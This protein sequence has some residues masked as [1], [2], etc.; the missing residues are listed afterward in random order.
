M[1]QRVLVT[2]GG[3]FIGSHL[4]E[5]LEATGFDVSV[6]DNFAVNSKVKLPARVKIFRADVSN[7]KVSD[8]VVKLKPR[9]V[10][11]LAAD[12]RVTSPPEA[13]IAS[14]IIGTYNLL[15]G[16]KKAQAKQF[17]FTSSAAVYGDSKRLPIK[18]TDPTRPISAYGISKLTGEVYCGLFQKHFLTSI[19]RFANVYGPRQSSAAEGGA[20][21]IFIRKMLTGE[22]LIVYGD[23]R[24]TRDFVFVGDV[25]DALMLALEKHTSF[26]V[27]IGSGKEASI[28]EL[29]FQ[30]ESLTKIKPKINNQPARPVEIDHSLFSHDLATKILGWRPETNL[31]Q[32]LKL[33]LDYYQ[34]L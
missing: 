13:T 10:F 34:S 5:R 33:T 15:N 12:N 1:K 26:K 2:G 22:P 27:N 19:F 24:Q 30:L 6:I 9:I 16:A 25:V 17:I 11:H 4:V 3:G 32:G 23:G 14:N 18:E 29:L 21:A 31:T 7:P 8:L 20:V 28:K